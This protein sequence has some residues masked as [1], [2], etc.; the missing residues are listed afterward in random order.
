MLL[1]RFEAWRP[2]LVQKYFRISLY[3]PYS[4][5]F[6][7][8]FP[9]EKQ[10]SDNLRTSLLQLVKPDL[11]H[12]R[13]VLVKENIKVVS[14]IEGP[15]ATIAVV[16]KFHSGKSFLKNQLMGKTKGFGIGP[17]VRPETMG[18]WMWGQP[19]KV[20]LPSGQNL[21]L[22][23]LDTEGFAANNVSENYD[24]KIFA[25]ATLISSHL[26][27]NSVKIIDQADI[28][29]L[30]L[31][32]RRTQL[33]ALRSQ[34]SRAKWNDGFV[35]DLL[36]FPPLL[37]VVQDFVQTTLDNETP[38]QWL[39]RLMETLSRESE[40]YKISLLDI[41]KS[42]ECH[43]LFLP[44]VKRLLLTDLSEAREEDL[45][46]EYIEE[47]DALSKKLL[48]TLVP[49]TKNGRPVTGAEL[50]TLF[51]VLVEASNDGSL[52]DVPSR[53][54]SFVERIMDSST[55]DC[56]HFYESEMQVLF[57]KNDDGPVKEG[58]LVEWHAQ[59][60]KKLFTLL[61]QLLHGLSDALESASIQLGKNL[62][63]LHAR[64][65]DL[66]S[67]KVR[68]FCSNQEQKYLL[69]AEGHARGIG[70]PINSAILER[71]LG[72]FADSL[73]TD[74]AKE[75]DSVLEEEDKK[76]YTRSLKQSLAHLID[77]SQLQNERAL[78]AVFEKAAAA[79]SDTMF[80]SQLLN[81]GR[82]KK[83]AQLQF[84]LGKVFD[85]ECKRFSSEKKYGLH[86]AL[87]KDVINRRME[88]LRKENDQFISKLMADTAE[89]RRSLDAF[90]TSPE[91][92]KSSQELLE[93][94]RSVEKQ[95][96]TENV[97]AF[98]RVVG[99]PLRRAKQIIL[100]SADKFGT[101]FTLRSFI[102]DACLLQLGDGKPKFW[103]QDF[104]R[105]IVNNFM[106]SDP[107]LR[108]RIDSIK[109]FWSS[110]VGFFLWILWLIGF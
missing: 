48:A 55:E 47:R 68:L 83:G 24:A 58:V 70:L 72:A 13:L 66:N 44:A 69:T 106:N 30:E 56:T 31:L 33:F 108:Q 84:S 63:S 18:I 36:S 2:R 77:A 73:V 34:L 65:R 12:K 95:R 22:I 60:K 17:T 74:F 90:Q 20:R 100:L 80:V 109:G 10:I 37:W 91:Y 107:E 52:A 97:A 61:T 40:D 76:T 28:D 104:K 38:T 14:K 5:L 11:N 46:E 89:F 9:S 53:W 43:T 98:T 75:L 49:K 45:T 21:S 54:T 50:V 79:A 82:A 19:L 15:V 87:L 3:L 57:K 94:L 105:N 7:A 6:P 26:I 78:E 103:Q 35:H 51:E 85:S 64:Q 93:K 71:D 41:F 92:K 88:D 67:K 86:E 99:E 39:H 29:Y 81:L 96:R 25:V 102:M 23:F 4:Y 1:P 27:Y 62:E 59:A 8:W 32:A 42:L 16:G 101:E 110:V